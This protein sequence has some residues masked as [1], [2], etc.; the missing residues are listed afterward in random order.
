MQAVETNS[1]HGTVRNQVLCA[2][3]SIMT[4]S[5]FFCSFL[6]F[7]SIMVVVCSAVVGVCC[8][9]V[10]TLKCCGSGA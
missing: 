6:L 2:V 7:L 8:V 4:G 3:C 9:V 10:V 5:G 1:P